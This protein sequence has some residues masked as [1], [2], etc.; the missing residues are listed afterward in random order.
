MLLVSIVACKDDDKETYSQSAKDCS[1]SEAITMDVIEQVL[2]IVPVYIVEGKYE[3]DSNIVLSASPALSEN[4]YPKTITIDYGTGV[5]GPDGNIRKGKIFLEVNSGTI[6]SEDLSISFDEFNY[7]GNTLYGEFELMYSN[8]GKVN[9][10]SDFSAGNLTFV[11]A[12]GTMKW[13]SSFVMSRQEG[14]STSN[15]GDD[16][17][18]FS[19]TA[20]GIDLSGTSYSLVTGIEHV[21]D[22]NCKHFIKSGS[23]V[24]TPNEKGEQTV[25][26]G[27]GSCDANGSI[28]FTGNTVQNFSF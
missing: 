18:S 2:T 23:S 4:T 19:G 15:I 17:F 11:S 7:N 5:T 8:P 27:S 3:A 24:L 12:N 9:Y 1:T 20:D 21:I 10:T 6:L 22:F 26:Y 28:T 14:G 16:V 25:S 13:K